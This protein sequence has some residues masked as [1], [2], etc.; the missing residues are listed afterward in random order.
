[1]QGELCGKTALFTTSH[2]RFPILFQPANRF[3]RNLFRAH[4]LEASRSC[5]S[6][7]LLKQS[8]LHATRIVCGMLASYRTL[9]FVICGCTKVRLNLRVRELEWVCSSPWELHISDVEVASK[10]FWVT[11]SSIAAYWSFAIRCRK[12]FRIFYVRSRSKRRKQHLQTYSG[13][14]CAAFA[15]WASSSKL[16]DYKFLISFGLDFS[17]MWASSRRRNLHHPHGADDV[18]YDHFQISSWIPQAVATVT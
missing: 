11:A 6:T 7:M 14:A 10:W 17:L 15:W 13:L 3:G 8:T 2:E 9:P 12:N 18:R 16:Q 1:M 5:S 4:N